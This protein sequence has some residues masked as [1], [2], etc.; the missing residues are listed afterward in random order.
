MCNKSIHGPQ[1]AVSLSLQPL[2]EGSSSWSFDRT[3]RHVGDAICE[4]HLNINVRPVK[5]LTKSSEER[6]EKGEN[7]HSPVE[8]P[9]VLDK[10]AW[11][12]R[13]YKMSR[14]IRH[15]NQRQLTMPEM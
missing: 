12:T 15:L 2:L 14:H 13:K 6:E 8:E 9:K 5:K 3:E 7:G 11:C 1:P 10:K 4:K